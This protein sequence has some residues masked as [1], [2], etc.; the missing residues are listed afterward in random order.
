MQTLHRNHFYTPRICS[1]YF[2]GWM[3]WK[4][5]GTQAI[6][7]EGLQMLLSANLSASPLLRGTE[8][9]RSELCRFLPLLS[10]KALMCRGRRNPRDK[11]EGGHTHPCLCLPRPEGPA[12][13]KDSFSCKC[14]FSGQRWVWEKE[15]SLEG[16]AIKWA[17][18]LSVNLL[19]SRGEVIVQIK[20]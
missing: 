15:S 9:L 1:Y 16:R 3:Q 19:M 17:E 4:V 10:T 13:W 11:K 2:K 8:G 20:V 12:W 5:T 14:V 18:R 6:L 7:S